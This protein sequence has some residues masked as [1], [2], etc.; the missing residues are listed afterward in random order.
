MLFFFLSAF[1]VVQRFAPPAFPAVKFIWPVILAAAEEGEYGLPAKA[2]NKA[3]V[4]TRT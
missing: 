1:A 3:G 2:G 4:G